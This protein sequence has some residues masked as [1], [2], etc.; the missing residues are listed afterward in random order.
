MNILINI[1]INILMKLLL[2][3]L[4]LQ[5][6]LGTIYIEEVMDCVENKC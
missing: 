3:L 1:N 6:V 4:L 5:S 2:S